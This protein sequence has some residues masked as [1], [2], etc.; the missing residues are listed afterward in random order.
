MKKIVLLCFLLLSPFITT[1]AHAFEKGSGWYVAPKLMPTGAITSYDE[2]HVNYGLTSTN[3][4]FPSGVSWGIA[5]GKDFSKTS[6]HNINV[7]L[8]YF[9]ASL[10]DTTGEYFTYNDL[11]TQ[12][13]EALLT[14]IFYNLALSNNFSLTTCLSLGLGLHGINVESSGRKMFE[15]QL[16]AALLLGLGCGFLFNI[17]ENWGLDLNTRFLIIAGGGSSDDIFGYGYHL[18]SVSIPL[19]AVIGVR[20][21]F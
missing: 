10:E 19:Q 4:G 7:E 5:L 1:N 21:Y 12:R 8:E 3:T 18:E 13:I 14:N 9:H 2:Y 6:F 15:D 16:Q 11:F 20:Y 17:T